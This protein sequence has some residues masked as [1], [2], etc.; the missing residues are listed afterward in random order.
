[1]TGTNVL[2]SNAVDF[3]ACARASFQFVWTGAATGSY[4]LEASNDG[5]NWSD[6]A[7]ATLAVTAASDGFINLSDCNSRYVRAVY[8]N[9]TST[10]VVGVCTAVGK[11]N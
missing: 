11:E 9:A 10:G 4:K 3:A 5:V 6:I 8:T 2:T 1:M 7:S